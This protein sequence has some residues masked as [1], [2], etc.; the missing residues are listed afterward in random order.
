M[1]ASV[2]GFGPVFFGVVS[3]WSATLTLGK[4]L[5]FCAEFVEFWLRARPR[6]LSCSS[7]E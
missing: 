5:T 2:E 6:D 4:F 3:V 7:G 1:S